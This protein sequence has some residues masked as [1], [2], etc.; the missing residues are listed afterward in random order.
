VAF[1]FGWGLLVGLSLAL[2][3][4]SVPARHGHLAQAGR[5]ASAQLG[6]GDDL[7]LRFLS[8]GAYALAALSL[9]ILFVLGLTLV[10]MA[11]VWRNWDDWRPLFFSA[12]FVTYSVWVTP[13]LDALALPPAWQLL[14]D[15]I[16]AV[17]LFMAVSFFLLFHDGSFVPGWT[18][19]SALG[20]ALY[21]L[22][23]GL[24]PACRLA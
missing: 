18:R 10:S 22:L 1:R 17:G 15:L 13:T 3:V 23:W 20:W 8:H 14:A 16:Q 12:T 11:I 19:L 21:C 7:L 6:P 24:F 5:R 9:E 4:L 2:F